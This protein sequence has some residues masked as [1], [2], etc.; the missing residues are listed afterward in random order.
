[1][2]PA[3]KSES[4]MSGILKLC[5]ASLVY[6]ADH[7]RARLPTRHSLLSTYLFRN[8][9][10]MA[11]LRERVLT[12]D[13][14]WMSASGIPPH[15]EMYKQ[16]EDTS[17]AVDRLPAILLEGFSKLLDEKGVAAGNITKDVLECTIRKLLSEAGLSGNA[18][19][20]CEQASDVNPQRRLFYWNNKYHY[21]PEDFEFP[22]TD[23]LTAWKLWW[24]G[25]AALGYPPLKSISTI[26][27]STKKKASTFSEWSIFM[28]YLIN[29]IVKETGQPL[30]KKMSEKKAHEL[31]EV[32]I[33]H[34][35]ILPGVRER[36]VSQL[37]ITT[38][39]RLVR[40][41]FRAN[42]PNARSVAYRKR[43]HAGAG[44]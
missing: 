4:N 16:Q 29:A 24:F 42:N 43:K 18:N 3:L 2:F 31:F 36:R 21:L 39:L 1:M 9:S 17:K 38:A 6:H 32:G 22:S 28:K 44:T 14:P 27:L 8:M 41:G 30:P 35:S 19:V 12:N 23:P 33:A 37:K 26:D 34:L 15:I 11:Y 13:S 25:N 40:E 5:L 7:L 20:P 10:T